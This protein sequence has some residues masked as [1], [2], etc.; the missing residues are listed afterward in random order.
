MYLPV[1]A[2]LSMRR[3]SC[4][5]KAKCVT[6][7][8]QQQTT[9]VKPPAFAPTSVVVSGSEIKLVEGYGNNYQICE[10]N[11]LVTTIQNVQQVK[12]LHWPLR[13]MHFLRIFNRLYNVSAKTMRQMKAC[14]EYHHCKCMRFVTKIC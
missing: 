5:G 6:F 13:N 10:L 8:Q 2:S 4:G 12:F 14:F 1:F 11:I 9:G 3:Q 7:V